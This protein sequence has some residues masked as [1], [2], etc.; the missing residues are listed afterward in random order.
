MEALQ[1]RDRLAYTFLVDG[2]SKEAHVTYEQLDQQAQDAGVSLVNYSTP[3]LFA[4]QPAIENAMK[5]LK[6]NDGLLPEPCKCGV[7][8]EDC[9]AILNENLARR[10]ITAEC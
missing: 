2:E 5:S 10:A 1:Q 3:C 9:N 6:E 7:D 8:V 4:A